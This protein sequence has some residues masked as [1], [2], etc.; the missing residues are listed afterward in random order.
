MNSANP[1]LMASG[2]VAS[3]V[4][5]TA[6]L[7]ISMFAT[8]WT[9]RHRDAVDRPLMMLLARSLDRSGSFARLSTVAS[10]AHNKGSS[11][12]RIG[13]PRRPKKPT[14][15]SALQVTGLISELERQ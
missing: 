4:R 8:L 3:S 14:V 15:G 9:P 10:R 7:L 11:E 12:P 1:A 13:V 6:T 2:A 5:P